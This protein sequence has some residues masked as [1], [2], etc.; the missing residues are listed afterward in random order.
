MPLPDW[1]EI[2][3]IATGFASRLYLAFKTASDGKHIRGVVKRL[4]DDAPC[5]E[6]SLVSFSDESRLAGLLDHPNIVKAIEFGPEAVPPYIVLE[7]V[8]G[9][10]LGRLMKNSRRAGEPFPIGAAVHVLRSIF[11]ALDSLHNA[12]DADGKPM[13]AIHRDVTPS[14]VLL[15]KTGDVKLAD[16][17]SSE[18]DGMKADHGPSALMAQPEYVSPET[19]GGAYPDKRSDIYMAGVIAWELLTG[20]RLFARKSNE[21]VLVEIE[22][23]VIPSPKPFRSDLPEGL[24]LWVMRLCAKAPDERPR[25]AS[26]ALRQLDEICSASGVSPDKSLLIGLIRACP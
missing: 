25:T 11:L 20:R 23:T 5:I 14:N 15:S 26:N 19:A 1:H 24:D 16:F 9:P 7:H 17:G 22:G 12:A 18:F 13:N 10:D 4:R 21:N 8:N 6:K 3:P 2:E